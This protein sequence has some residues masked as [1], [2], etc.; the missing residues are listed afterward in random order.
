ML[1]L[2][3]SGAGLLYLHNYG[4]LPAFTANISTR[5]DPVLS[6]VKQ[7]IAYIGGA[8]SGIAIIGSLVARKISGLTKTKNAV[9]EQNE[10]LQSTLA[11]TSMSQ[12]TVQ[13]ELNVAKQKLSVY[14]GQFGGDVVGK[15]QNLSIQLQDAQKTITTQQ[16]EIKLF[17]ERQRNLEAENQYW[18]DLLKKAEYERD[19]AKGIIKEPI[20]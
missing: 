3:C 2:V 18:Q 17:T 19:V 16:D 1:A 14:E 9:V 11:N 7:N 10:V 8:F 4:L 13:E 20:P 5:L 6:F 12:N 15:V